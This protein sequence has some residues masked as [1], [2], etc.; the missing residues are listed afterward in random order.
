MHTDGLTNNL[1]IAILPSNPIEVRIIPVSDRESFHTFM[2]TLGVQPLDELEIPDSNKELAERISSMSPLP[3]E[4]RK[5]FPLLDIPKLGIAWI[6]TLNGY[7]LFALENI[8]PGTVIGE[9]AGRLSKRNECANLDYAFHYRHPHFQ[10]EATAYIDGR[11][12][13]NH[14][15][16]INH[17]RTSTN[18][19]SSIYSD[20]T[21]LRVV[22]ST[23]QRIHS[24]DELT[25][26]YQSRKA[27]AWPRRDFERLQL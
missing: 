5:A 10:E 8:N 26:D 24:G 2:D 27:W 9:Y 6:N 11:G 1:F 3:P 16:F 13:G 15:R 7:G 20:G 17:R 23:Y 21:Y 14:T 22:L 19:L 4:F 12:Q 18:L 25:F